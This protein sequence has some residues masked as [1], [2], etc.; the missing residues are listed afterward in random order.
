MAPATDRRSRALSGIARLL[1]SA[2]I[3][4]GMSAAA[5]ARADGPVVIKAGTLHIGNGQTIANAIVVIVDGKILAVGPGVPIPS[6]ATIIDMPKGSITPGLID[7]NA[8]I[9]PADVISRR[10]VGGPGAPPPP[11]DAPGHKSPSAIAMMF[12]GGHDPKNCWSCSGIEACAFA[13]I[14]D[15]LQ[16][17]QTCPC[18][19]FPN[20]GQMES[21]ISG[22]EQS[23]SLTESSS[24]VVPHTRVIDTMNLRSPDFERLVLGG[25]TTVFISP[26]SAA[27]IGPQGAVVRT[28]GPMMDRI[29]TPASDV[30]AAMGTDSFTVGADNSPPFRQFVTVTTRRPNTRMGVTWVFRKAFYD[31]KEWKDGQT[32]GGADTPPSEAF[33]QLE[34]I[35]AGKTPLRMQARMQHDIRTAVRLADEFGLKFTLLEGNEAYKEVALLKE[36][37]IPVIYGPLSIDPAGTRRFAADRGDPR[38]STVRELL[39]A[40]VPVALSAQDLREEDGLARQ[41]MYAVRAGVSPADAIKAVTLTP[42][43]MLG[44]DKDVGSIEAGKRA[45]LVLWSGEPLDATS[46]PVMVLIGGRTVMDLR[47]TPERN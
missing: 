30:K 28:A 25:V 15:D 45:D 19:G 38:L 35:L 9:E 20:V 24:E 16:P 12:N 37:Q 6:G 21:L 3:F 34:S 14:H 29:I 4:A 39:D 8:Q 1:A 32:P 36:R 26:D 7:A 43:K 18:C 41:A 42:A 46:R 31:A 44:I 22:V 2:A 47:E 40:G 5:L 27:V 23:F 10:A 13:N 17:E 11:P 33:P